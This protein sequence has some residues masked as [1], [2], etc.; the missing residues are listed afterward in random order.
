MEAAESDVLS[1]LQSEAMS[2]PPKTD[3][4]SSVMKGNPRKSIVGKTENT[5]MPSRVDLSSIQSGMQ[6]DDDQSEIGSKVAA[7]ILSRQGAQ[8]SGQAGNNRKRYFSIFE[9]NKES[10]VVQRDLVGIESGRESSEVK[11]KPKK[12]RVLAVNQMN[13][14]VSHN[15]QSLR[16]SS[17]RLLDQ[18]SRADHSIHGRTVKAY[19]VPSLE[20]P[21][22]NL[23]F[24]SSDGNGLVGEEQ[25]IE[26]PK[27]TLDRYKKN[28]I[29]RTNH[30]LELKSLMK[31]INRKIVVRSISMKKDDISMI[32]NDL[33]SKSF[34]FDGQEAALP[35]KPLKINVSKLKIFTNED[36]FEG[37][38]SNGQDQNGQP[39]KRSGA[40]KRSSAQRVYLDHDSPIKTKTLKKQMEQ[41]KLQ[42]E[43]QEEQKSKISKFIKYPVILE[44]DNSEQNLIERQ[45]AIDA[46]VI[47]GHSRRKERV[48]KNAKSATIDDPIKVPLLQPNLINLPDSNLQIK[49]PNIH[50]SSPPVTKTLKSIGELVLMPVEGGEDLF[51]VDHPG[52]DAKSVLSKEISQ[53][54]SDDRSIKLPKSKAVPRKSTISMPAYKSNTSPLL[55]S[56]DSGKRNPAMQDSPGTLTRKEHPVFDKKVEYQVSKKSPAK[57]QLADDYGHINDV[58]HPRFNFD[59]FKSFVF[60]RPIKNKAGFQKF[61]EEIQVDFGTVNL[62]TKKEDCPPKVTL[63][64]LDRC[65]P[66]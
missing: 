50:L 31:K 45:E 8:I 44:Q 20:L 13:R 59:R 22:N 4:R 53:K 26:T 1:K 40:R 47:T 10:L 29:L 43:G 48:L 37:L 5:R 32:S 25:S 7:G 9:S 64:K 58:Y 54:S 18:F 21:L 16:D 23:A 6:R 14:R 42:H 12:L 17:S 46:Q 41:F 62:I 60:S 65:K 38:D 2:R 56:E 49:R 33:V 39:I 66:P 52:F 61:L 27:G 35:K 28:S 15:D 3:Q 19:P 63:F 34:S 55:E 51:S 24:R 36:D 30:K 11:A 57:F